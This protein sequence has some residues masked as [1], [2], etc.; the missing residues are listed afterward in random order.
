M[1]AKI[2]GE[3]TD[4]KVKRLRVIDLIFQKELLY[5]DVPMMTLLGLLMLE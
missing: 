4:Q 3:M 1:N 5:I 2:Y